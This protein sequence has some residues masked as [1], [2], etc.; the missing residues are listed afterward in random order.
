M[1]NEDKRE[2]APRTADQAEGEREGD[3]QG[4]IAPITP[5]QAE[6]ERDDPDAEGQS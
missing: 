5:G 2:T 3:N 6:G 4:A 1:A